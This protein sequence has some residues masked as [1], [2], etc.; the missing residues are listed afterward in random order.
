MNFDNLFA[1]RTKNMGA[2]AIRE[3][4]KVVSQPGIISLAGGIPAPES[5]PLKLFEELTQKVLEK[6]A[7][8]SLQYDVTEGFTPLRQALVAFLHHKGIEAAPAGICISSGSQGVLDAIGKIMISKGDH[9]AV[10]APTY[11]GAISAFNPYEPEYHC[12]EM[13][14]DGLLPESLEQTLK[15]YPIKF[16]Y[17]VP[18]FQNPTGRTLTLERRLQI[19]EIIKRHETLLVEDDPYSDLRYRGTPLPTLKSLVPDQV[20][21]TTTLSK[22]FAPGLRIGIY[23]APAPVQR[24]MIYA[25]QGIDLH[26]STFNQA[27]ATEYIVGGYLERQVPI[28][29]ALYKPKQ[30]AMLTALE[31]YF[32]DSY[33]WS[34]PEGG[35]FIWAEGPNHLEAEKLYWKCIERKTAFV[36]GKFFYP[37]E[38]RG[39]SSM[40]LNY[41]MSDE[42]SIDRAIKTIGEV[43]RSES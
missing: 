19:A 35:M 22:I 40:R 39:L 25:K 31:K 41:T 34:R 10:E 23:L 6:Y 14:D 1:G 36:P 17:L 13:D 33:S 37:C 2:N 26:S 3:I 7:S 11:V 42:S 5:F 20:V 24:W 16:V 8:Y 18:T 4:L 21:Y 43:I 15:K 38:G 12:L 32:P 29:T 27:L 28:I 30:E 9:I